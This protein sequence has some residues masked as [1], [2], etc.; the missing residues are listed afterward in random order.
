MLG[1]RPAEHVETRDEVST[2]STSEAGS[3]SGVRSTSV[4]DPM[5]FPGA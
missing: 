1:R 5:A 2:S 4:S 3:T